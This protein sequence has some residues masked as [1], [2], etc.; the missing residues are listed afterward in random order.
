MLKPVA[1][2]VAC[3]LVSLF[4]L[5]GSVAPLGA[6]N[7]SPDESRVAQ[8]P[9]YRFDI[10]G[11]PLDDVVAAFR[12][13]TGFR[14]TVPSTLQAITSP[15]VTGVFTAEQAL[16]R[17]LS[18]TSVAF[19]LASTNAYVLE[20]RLTQSVEVTA[21]ILPYRPADSATATRTGTPLRDI[22][23]TLTVL[24]RELLNDQ[25]ARS[26]GEALRNVAGVTVAQGE[27]NRDQIVLRGINTTSDFFVN[28]VRDD[29]ERFRDLYNVQS[30][31]VLQ[32]PAAVLFGRGGAGGVVN[33]VTTRAM[34]GMPSEVS[35]ETG[36]YDRKRATAQLGLSAGPSAAFRVSAMAESSG[37]F[38]ESYFLHRYGIN[39]TTSF[40][41][42]SA[43]TMT[44]GFEHL[45]DRRL[46]DRGSRRKPAS[47]WTCLR[48]SFSAPPRRTKL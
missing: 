31:E 33:L 23:Q 43:T 8:L 20:V 16:E 6:G 12:T 39:P 27:G 5:L 45:H 10:P 21:R 44:L 37:G 28:G 42:G 41:V 7:R 22:P 38:R 47:P 24:S 3:T 32:G 13:V 29:Q 40:N 46:A 2:V 9:T 35:V 17:L 19:R 14:V 11:G 34:R 18:G 25:N 36:S 4:G 30:L 1:H 15:G 48:A 26:V